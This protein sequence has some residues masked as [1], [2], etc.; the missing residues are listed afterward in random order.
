M[1]GSRMSKVATQALSLGAIAWALSGCGGG[2]SGQAKTAGNTSTAQSSAQTT[3]TA[4][5]ARFIASTGAICRRRAPEVEA[6]NIYT[7]NVAAIITAARRRAGI[8]RDGL[9]ELEAL[10][11]PSSMAGE[12]K[13]YIADAKSA[14]ADLAK[15]GDFGAHPERAPFESSYYAYIKVLEQMRAAAQQLALAGCTHYG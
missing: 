3:S 13:T 6:A 2:G 8:E 14:Q 7:S 1:S 4:G 5:D 11:P 12:W 15:L 10:T 9:R